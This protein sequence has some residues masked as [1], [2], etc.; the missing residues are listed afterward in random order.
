MD[1]LLLGGDDVH[2]LAEIWAQV[3]AAPFVPRHFGHNLDALADVAGDLDA[4]I[5]VRQAT[6]LAVRMGPDF[7]RLW[8][9][10]CA[11]ARANPRLVLVWGR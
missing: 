5:V 7:D 8:T 2:T 11:A 3:A 4:V 9:V 6:A 1:T 10:L